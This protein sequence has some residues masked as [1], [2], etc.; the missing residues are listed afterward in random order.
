MKMSFKAKK[1]LVRLMAAAALAA[2]IEAH[3]VANGGNVVQYSENETVEVDQAF[4]DKVR[5]SGVGPAKAVAMTILVAEEVGFGSEVKLKGEGQVYKVAPDG[6]GSRLVPASDAGG[7]SARELGKEEV[8][9]DGFGCVY[10][11]RREGSGG[12]PKLVPLAKHSEDGR[13][14][15]V[16]SAKSLSI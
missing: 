15:C 12:Q 11:V 16:S 10:I 9:K 3:A 7:R 4:M 13:A 8:I 1:F 14:M 5:K 2:S 6:I